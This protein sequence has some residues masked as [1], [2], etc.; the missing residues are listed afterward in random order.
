[1]SITQIRSSVS[2]KWKLCNDID[3]G[4]IEGKQLD[5]CKCNII[6]CHVDCF[7]LQGKK[8]NEGEVFCVPNT[9]ETTS[10]MTWKV[11]TKL[12][13]VCFK[14]TFGPQ[15]YTCTEDVKQI[16]HYKSAKFER[17]GF[18]TEMLQ[19]KIQLR[20]WQNLLTRGSRTGL[21]NSVLY[22]LICKEL[23]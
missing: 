14:A 7:C 5:L 10:A 15:I 4:S 16:K 19:T 21:L 3:V 12:Q 13:S 2:L 17:S 6:F 20:K 8:D 18:S 1:M 23:L 22:G 9:L 11:L